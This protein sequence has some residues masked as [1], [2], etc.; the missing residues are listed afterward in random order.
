MQDASPIRI[1]GETDRVYLRTRSACVIHDPGFERRIDVK[2]NGVLVDRD[3]S[4]SKSVFSF[5]AQHAFGKHIHQEQVSVSA[6]GDHAQA[7][8]HNFLCQHFGVGH[9][10]PGIIFK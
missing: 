10:L 6:A 8:I 3:A 7:F 4:L 2:R 9:H 1:T 5:T